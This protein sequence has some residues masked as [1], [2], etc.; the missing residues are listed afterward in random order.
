MR[1]SQRPH[2]SRSITLCFLVSVI[3]TW[4][5]PS[6]FSAGQPCDVFTPTN[7]DKLSLDKKIKVSEAIRTC[8]RRLRDSNTKDLG[9]PQIDTRGIAYITAR[10]HRRAY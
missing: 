1:T 7:F 5:A 6:A 2:H 8:E 10:A 9:S 3:L 4:N